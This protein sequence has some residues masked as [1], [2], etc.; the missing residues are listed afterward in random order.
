MSRALAALLLFAATTVAALAQ[1]LPV[2]SRWSSQNHSYLEFDQMVNSAEFTG[3]YVD[4]N[5]RFAC[6]NVLKKMTG[7]V[8]GAKV[9]F[10]VEWWLDG[11]AQCGQ[12]TWTGHAS[13]TTITAH[14]VHTVKGQP[15]TSGTDTFTRQR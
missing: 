5:P 3:I 7:M 11:A 15:P 14:W 10:T 9:T 12:T 2:P 8:H 13:G 4:H 1:T 6:A